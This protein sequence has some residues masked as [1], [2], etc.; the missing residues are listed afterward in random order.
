MNE[1]SKQRFD[2]IR[3]NQFLKLAT[4]STS[5]GIQFCIAQTTVL[6]QLK[7]KVKLAIANF[8]FTT[9]SDLPVCQCGEKFNLQHAFRQK[10]LYR[11]ETR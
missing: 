10:R 8:R 1:Q 11:H 4:C 2:A 9:N 5:Q 6:E 7:T 3:K